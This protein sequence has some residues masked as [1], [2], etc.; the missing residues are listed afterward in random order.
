M[1]RS[2]L[3]VLVSAALLAA[4][5]LAAPGKAKPPAAGKPCPKAGA[6]GKSATRAALICRRRNGKLVWTAIPKTKPKPPG[7]PV[8]RPAAGLVL[9]ASP[10]DLSQIAQISKFRS[11]AGHDYSAMGPDGRPEK[12]RSMKHYFAPVASLAG[13]TGKVKEFSP[14][15]GT[16]SRVQVEQNPRGAQVWVSVGSGFGSWNVVFFHLDLAA[17]LAQGSKVAAGQLIGYANLSGDANDFDIAVAKFGPGGMTLDSLLNRLTPSVAQQFAARGIT[18]ANAI[19]S[20]ADRDASPCAFGG[21]GP[22]N[23]ADWVTLS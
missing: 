4:G 8:P 14:V 23:P 9:S 6:R 17:G 18:P 11:C 19:V 15:A 10:V 2:I 7:K 13:S 3:L 5:A 21:G 20:K 1:S 22:A 12:N 16:I